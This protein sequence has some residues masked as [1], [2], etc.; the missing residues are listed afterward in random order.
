MG[1]VPIIILRQLHWLLKKRSL[2][3]ASP[4]T[5]HVAQ[6]LD[7]SFFGPLKQHWAKVCCDYMA[8]NPGRVVTKFQFS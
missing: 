2:F 6:P 3:S 8:D 7:V 5:T 4:H 1:I